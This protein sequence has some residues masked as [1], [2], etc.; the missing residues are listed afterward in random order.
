MVKELEISSNWTTSS[1]GIFKDH[2]M[3]QSFLAYQWS[4]YFCLVAKIPLAPG[5]SIKGHLVCTVRN[6]LFSCLW[7]TVSVHHQGKFFFLCNLLHIA[8]QLGIVIQNQ[9]QHPQDSIRILIL[10][11]DQAS[12]GF[13]CVTADSIGFQS[14][15]TSCWEGGSLLLCR[16]VEPVTATQEREVNRRYFFIQKRKRGG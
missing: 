9:C 7:G 3:A 2:R 8:V 14:P 12:T 6:S 16:S 11:Q 15:K 10:S 1:S 5:F 4:R 13:S